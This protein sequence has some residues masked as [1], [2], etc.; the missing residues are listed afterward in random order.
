M[1]TISWRTGVN[2]R[3]F[4]Y[5]DR[6][7]FLPFPQRDPA[8]AVN[9][10]SLRCR[11][12]GVPLV[13]F[14]AAQHKAD[15]N[16][17]I[18]QVGLALDALQKANMQAI[19]CLG[20]SLAPSGFTVPGDD[21]YHQGTPLGHLN[22]RYWHEPGYTKNYFPYVQ[23]LVA[24]YANHPAVLAWE[25]GNEFAIQPQPS[26]EDDFNAFLQFAKIVSRTS[27]SARQTS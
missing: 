11:N 2:M 7:E 8:H 1:I 23:K 5:Y 12:L 13:R 21:D 9:F 18:A 17:N 26:S 16:T 27:N 15:V 24:Q 4:A 22:K 10:R 25:L 6:R 3:E 19:V 14:F 20:D